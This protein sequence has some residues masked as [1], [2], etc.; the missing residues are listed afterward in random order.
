[1]Y[2]YTHYCDCCSF[3]FFFAFVCLLV[4]YCIL[5]CRFCRLSDPF[6]DSPLLFTLC[7][8]CRIMNNLFASFNYLPYTLHPK[9]SMTQAN[10]LESQYK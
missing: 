1:M 2:M 4:L 10:C 3:F 7:P 6:H 8:K 5:L 9:N